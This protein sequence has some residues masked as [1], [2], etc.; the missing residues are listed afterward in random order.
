[1]NRVRRLFTATTGF[2]L[3]LCLA[4]SS[5]WAQG[6]DIPMIVTGDR[7]TNSWANAAYAHQFET[8]V[9]NSPAEF[10]RNNVSGVAGHRAEVSDSLFLVVNGAYQGSYY[11][12]DKGTGSAQLRWN[13][14]H[15]ASLMVGMGWKNDEWSV[16]GL[17]IGRTDGESGAD[18]DDTLTGG[19]AVIVDYKWSDELTTGFILGVT[20]TLEDSASLIPLP[21]VDW[22]F[23]DH[24]KLHFGVVSAAAYPG[25][26]PEISYLDEHWQFGFGGS[27]QTRRYRLDSRSGPTNKGIGQEQSFPVYARA[28]YAPN[29][30]VSFGAMAGVALGGQIRSGTSGG[31]K[32]FKEDYKA[33]PIVGLNAAFQF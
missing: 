17:L 2:C 33:A 16:I 30:N 29:K 18:F 1:M 24:W 10:S 8:D 12:F 23:A 3:L 22:R 7:D 26:G 6:I 21:T 15:R 27:Y 28:A 32:V 9:K 31:N 20:S 13:D 11:D 5:A 4:A 25:V 19:G 14:I